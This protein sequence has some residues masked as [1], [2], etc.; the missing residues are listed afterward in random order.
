MKRIEDVLHYFLKSS[1]NIFTIE[2]NEIIDD[3]NNIKDLITINK[4]FYCDNYEQILIKYGVRSI[5]EYVNKNNINCKFMVI[6]R[7]DINIF[8]NILYFYKNK[9]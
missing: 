8:D 2:Y 9:D 5:E 6:K 7:Y 1:E 3:E 4:G